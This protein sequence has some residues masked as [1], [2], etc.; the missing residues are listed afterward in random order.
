M[1]VAD[2]ILEIFQIFVIHDS[3]KV[4]HKCGKRVEGMRIHGIASPLNAAEKVTGN[5]LTLAAT[6]I[7]WFYVSSLKGPLDNCSRGKAGRACSVSLDRQ[8]HDGHDEHADVLEVSH[9]E[10]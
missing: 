3:R 8:D 10:N 2:E 5:D 7:S 6:G 9:C 1:G 4:F